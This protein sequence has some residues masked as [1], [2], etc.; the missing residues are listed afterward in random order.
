MPELRE[1]TQYKIAYERLRPLLLEFNLSQEELD[2]YIYL[3]VDS[4]KEEIESSGKLP[5]YAFAMNINLPILYEYNE[6]QFLEVMC[7]FDPLEEYLDDIVIENSFLLP[8]S[9][10]GRLNL[11]TGEYDCIVSWEEYFLDN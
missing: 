3:L 7:C 4:I 9:A 1:T 5:S 10:S 2:D 8:S 11:I 6:E